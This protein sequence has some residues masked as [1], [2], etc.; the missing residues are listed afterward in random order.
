MIPDFLKRENRSQKEDKML[1]A[2][3][4]YE[5]HFGQGVNTEPSPYSDEEWV[6]ILE[7]CVK[8]NITFEELTGEEYNPDDDY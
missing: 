8:E 1:I 4:Q 7:N 6:A 5:K 3:E 2:I